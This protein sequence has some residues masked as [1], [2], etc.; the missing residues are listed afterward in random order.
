MTDPWTDRYAS[1]AELT[2]LVAALGLD[3]IDAA[4]KAG[5]GSHTWDAWIWGKRPIPWAVAA[6]FRL[7][8]EARQRP[9]TKVAWC[10]PGEAADGPVS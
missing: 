2:S 9:A 6:M 8:L 5:V 10:A 1:V 4:R 3:P 7:M